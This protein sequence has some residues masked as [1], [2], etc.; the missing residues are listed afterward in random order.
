MSTTTNI[1]FSNVNQLEL[2]AP[3]NQH[4]ISHDTL[5]QEHTEP[6][7]QPT[8]TRYL[9]HVTGYQPIRDQYF[10]V[11]SVPAPPKTKTTVSTKIIIRFKNFSNKNGFSQSFALSQHT[12]TACSFIS[13][14]ARTQLVTK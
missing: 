13:L 9:G 14:P 3:E 1:L 7:K 4:Y 11:R 10:L 12:V 8:R 5:Q 6:S 2:V